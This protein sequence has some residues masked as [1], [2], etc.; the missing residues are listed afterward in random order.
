MVK[1]TDP[2][3]TRPA[4]HGRRAVTVP[5]RE[6]SF[7][8]ARAGGPGGQHVNKTETKVEARWNVRATRALPEAVRRRLVAALSHRL[9]EDGTLRVVARRSRSQ[10]ANREAALARLQTLVEAALKPVK[11]RRPTRPSAASRARR[12]EAKRMRSRKKALRRPVGE[13]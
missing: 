12:L 3:K 6:V 7:R 9:A 10:A 5:R 13:E 2:R 8:T 11:P 4:G 1:P